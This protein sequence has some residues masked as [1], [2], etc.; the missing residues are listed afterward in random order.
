MLDVAVKQADDDR[1]K[2]SITNY[3]DFYIIKTEEGY[4]VDAYEYN[5]NDDLID[6]INIWNHTFMEEAEYEDE[7]EAPSSTAITGFNVFFTGLHGMPNCE[8]IGVNVE[9]KVNIYVIR[10]NG[11]YSV[12]AYVNKNKYKYEYEPAI[13]RACEA[14]ISKMEILDDEEDN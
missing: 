11:G 14:S 9:N 8:S 2:V 13:T 1:I 4:V 6:T 7:D 10:I 12:E 5:S 3:A